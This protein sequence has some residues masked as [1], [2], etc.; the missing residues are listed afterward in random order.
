MNK[1][2]VD[3]L[4]AFKHTKRETLKDLAEHVNLRQEITLSTGVDNFDKILE[5]GFHSSR[6]YV[7]FGKNSTGKTQLCHQMCLQAS[8][9]DIKTIYLDTENSFR[10]ERIK[11][12]VEKRKI[13]TRNVLKEIL[14]S[15][16]MSS[17]TFLIK[18]DELTSYVKRKDFKLLIID[19]VNNYYRAEQSNP[20]FSSFMAKKNFL[21]LLEKLFFLVL[22][23]NLILICTAQVTQ[24]FLEDRIVQEL[25][26]GLQY[27][28]HYFT[29]FI[30]LSRELGTNYAHLINSQISPE[31]KLPFKITA[32]GI[33]DYV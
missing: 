20:E 33:E 7:L 3:V 26:V 29:E 24:N 11:Q 28:N 27:I 25:P 16:V 22:N 12:L 8:N 1:F 13:K 30:Y 31:K 5:G 32:R 19:S 9:Y 4:N 6:G 14:I 23:H 17:S 15:K 18:L 21:N 10:P 2:E